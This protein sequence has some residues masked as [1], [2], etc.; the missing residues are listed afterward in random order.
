MSEE[1][2]LEKKTIKGHAQGVEK[3]ERGVQYEC[4]FELPSDFGNVGAVLVQH[5]HHK[6]MFLRSIVLHDVPYGPVHFTCNSWVQPK[7]DCPVKRVFFSD[8]V[9][10]IKLL[11]KRLF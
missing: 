9:R 6:E 1:T 11:N 5:E 4:T 2:N 3:K 8:K 7:H 10:T